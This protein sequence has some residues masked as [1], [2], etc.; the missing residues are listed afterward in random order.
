MNCFHIL[1]S[2]LRWSWLTW[3]CVSLCF[4][5]ACID[6]KR[7]QVTSLGPCCFTQE[8]P[9]RHIGEAG[10]TYDMKTK[11]NLGQLPFWTSRRLALIDL[12][13]NTTMTEN[14]MTSAESIEQT[15]QKH[16]WYNRTTRKNDPCLSIVL[17]IFFLCFQEKSSQ[18]T[19][20]WSC[21][22][23]KQ[24]D[25]IGDG[26]INTHAIVA[27]SWEEVEVS[28][29]VRITQKEVIRTPTT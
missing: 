15:I 19:T 24:R 1:R 21:C 22:C 4:Q 9:G 28:G 8:C 3:C 13:W 6:M 20:M 10:G 5:V 12:T 29:L 27:S 7:S 23:T 2:K 14:N 18:L 25:V 17:C 26:L 16:F 11:E